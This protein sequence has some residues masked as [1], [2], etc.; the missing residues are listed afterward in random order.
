MASDSI[1][2]L[3]IICSSQ[4][5]SKIPEKN[6]T[7]KSHSNW[8]YAKEEWLLVLVGHPHYSPSS[9][10]SAPCWNFELDEAH[11]NYVH[12]RKVSPYIL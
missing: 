10:F 2:P 5:Q 3:K 8:A 12:G 4:M 7:V 9:T 6:S 1:Y 11:T